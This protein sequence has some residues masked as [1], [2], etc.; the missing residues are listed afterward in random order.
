MGPPED[1]TRQPDR[2]ER[3]RGKRP[4]RRPRGRQCLLKGC[5]RWFRPRRAR[6]R[7]CSPEC[8]EAAREWSRWKAQQKYRATAAGKKKRNGQSRRYR[9]RVRDRQP[10]TPEEVLPQAARVITPN[11]FSIAVV[12][13]RAATTGS[14]PSAGRPPGDS[15]RARAGAPWSGSGSA[16]GA[17]GASFC[18]S[19]GGEQSRRE[20]SRTY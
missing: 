16:N 12:T 10:A 5:E 17:G 9:E 20:I 13:A 19:G 2:R 1:C 18:R 11:F 14:P 3:A 15:V 8:R 6:Q 7:Y 4:R